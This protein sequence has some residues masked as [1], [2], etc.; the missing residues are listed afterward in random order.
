MCRRGKQTAL[1]LLL[2]YYVSAL[3]HCRSV[4][5]A[6]ASNV[7]RV[8]MGMCVMRFQNNLM[9]YEDLAQRLEATNL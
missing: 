2:L 1:P 5:A 7:Q 9:C 8:C 4:Y 3:D 6:V